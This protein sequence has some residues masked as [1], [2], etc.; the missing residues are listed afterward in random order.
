MISIQQKSH[1]PHKKLGKW[2][3]FLIALLITSH[4][5]SYN[6]NEPLRSNIQYK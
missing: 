4:A 5:Q 1:S 6:K 3:F 2:L